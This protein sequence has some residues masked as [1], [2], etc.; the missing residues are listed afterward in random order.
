MHPSVVSRLQRRTFIKAAVAA[1]LLSSTSFTQIAFAQTTPFDFDAFT[2][3]MKA[4]AA[5]PYD[6]TVPP[7]PEGFAALDYDSYRKVQFDPVKEEFVND[8]EAN[9]LRSRGKREWA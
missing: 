1:A 7:L 5:E 2:E 6:A 9:L 4:R 3:R 8:A